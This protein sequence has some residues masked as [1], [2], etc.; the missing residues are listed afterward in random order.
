VTVDPQIYCVPNDAEFAG[1]TFKQ[2]C[3]VK[4][5]VEIFGVGGQATVGMNPVALDADL[6]KIVIGNE[7]LFSI[8]S[9]TDAAKG[10]HLRTQRFRRRPKQP[11]MAQPR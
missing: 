11:A 8:A 7:N 2:G 6:D 5:R 9:A 1:N 3:T 4:G 10:P